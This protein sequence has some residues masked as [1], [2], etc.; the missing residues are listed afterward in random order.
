M[1]SL[2]FSDVSDPIGELQGF[3]EIGK[4]ETF[5]EPP[6]ALE[7]PFAGQ[8]FHKQFNHWRFQPATA[9]LTGFA[10]AI[11]QVHFP[12]RFGCVFH[13]QE[14]FPQMRCQLSGV[15]EPGIMG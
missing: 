6:A 8:S 1:M 13:K 12:W 7:L 10:L 2:L 9:V 11:C 4:A 5:L 14:S 15:L 3:F